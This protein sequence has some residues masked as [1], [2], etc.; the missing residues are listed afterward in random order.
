MA[1]EAELKRT[2]V[3]RLSGQD[4]GQVLNELPTQPVTMTSSAWSELLMKVKSATAASN[5]PQAGGDNFL[6]MID[7]TNR[8]VPLLAINMRL[9]ILTT[10]AILAET[11][12]RVKP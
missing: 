5:G 12:V 2:V 1:S 11:A 9:L 8:I 7:I 4:G 6:G 3:P 10:K